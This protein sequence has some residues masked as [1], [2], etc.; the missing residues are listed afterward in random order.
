M[1]KTVN[2]IGELFLNVKNLLL[3]MSC[4]NLVVTDC[5]SYIDPDLDSRTTSAAPVRSSG[6][7]MT[8]SRCHLCPKT[9]RNNNHLNMHLVKMHYKPKMLGMPSKKK[10][11]YFRIIHI[12]KFNSKNEH[13]MKEGRAVFSRDSDLRNSSVSP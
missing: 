12:Y 10:S 3:E 11:S 5:M 8:M 2:E 4:T 13:Y 6:R 7:Q 9:V 1:L